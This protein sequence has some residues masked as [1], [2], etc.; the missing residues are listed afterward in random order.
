V[1]V[2]MTDL[3]ATKGAGILYPQSMRV[4]TRARARQPRPR[5]IKRLNA[6]V[7]AARGAHAERRDAKRRAQPLDL[8]Q[9]IAPA[10][11]S[12]PNSKLRQTDRMERLDQLRRFAPRGCSNS[13][14]L[15]SWS[16]WS[17]RER[18]AKEIHLTTGRGT[19]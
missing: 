16:T 1:L 4:L 8:A 11:L 3:E 18:P 15:E 14:S 19:P 5:Q 10:C 9:S 13:N 17:N 2:P 6:P 12:D 7:G